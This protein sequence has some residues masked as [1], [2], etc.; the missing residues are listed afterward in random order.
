MKVRSILV[1]LSLLAILSTSVGGYLYHASLQESSLKE[2]E[3]QAVTRALGLR[4]HLSSYLLQ[5]LKSVR[6]MAGLEVFRRAL[7]YPERLE[8]V[9]EANR[10]L[11]H[12]QWALRA[13]V[14][15]L[16]DRRGTTIYSSNRDEPLS[17]VDKNYGFRPYFT[18]A[19]Q[20][21][22]AVYM[23][24]GVTSGKRGVYYSHPVYGSGPFSGPIGVGVIK[25]TIEP[26]ETEFSQVEGGIVVLADPDGVI[27]A[28]SRKD[29]LLH[30]LWDL[31]DK[32]RKRITASRQFGEGSLTWVGLKEREGRRA[33]DREGNR[34]M[35]HRIEVP[36]H[37]GWQILYLNSVD[38]FIERLSHP[39]IR[40]SGIVIL[41]LCLI[42][43]G[44][45]FVLYR[46]ASWEI[47]Q[48]KKAEGALRESEETARALLNAPTDSALLLDAEGRVLAAN[49]SAVRAFRT[50]VE[51]FVGSCIFAWFRPETA[52]SERRRLKT[53]LHSGKPIR[54][55]DRRGERFFD[56]HLYP[57]FGMKGRV[58]RVAI[59]SLDITEIKKTEE[60]LRRTQEELSRYSRNLERQ[61]RQRTREITSI[62]ENTP[63]VVTIKDREYRYTMVG[64]RFEELFGIT[65][66]D[67]KDKTDYEIFPKAVADQFR[68]ND[69]KVALEQKPIQVEE[70][71]P[72]EDGVHTYLSV[73]FPLND[74]TGSMLAMCGIST[75]ITE[76]KKAQD[77]LRRL[78]GRIMDSQEQERALI[79]RELHDELGQLL[80]AL[81]MDAVW[82]RNHLGRTNGGAESRASAMC[83]LIDRTID[84]V[85]GI[86]IRLRPGVLDD[87]GLIEALEWYTEEFDRRSEIVC[88]FRHQDIPPIKDWIATAAYRI[89]Q[90]AM[91]NAARH[92]SAAN[93]DVSLRMEDHW[94]VLEVM[95][96][97]RGFDTARLSEI[98]CLGVA[99][100]RERAV[101]V[102]GSLEIRSRP[103]QGTRV[104]FH[105]PL[106][107]SPGGGNP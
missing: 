29:W 9:V 17:F 104:R 98:D 86:A 8:N 84:E 22:T 65:S 93:V 62:L 58:I 16:M 53:I 87:L 97:G 69:E 6:A 52:E 19:I 44:G 10:L 21:E 37:P 56:T 30:L 72:Q 24:L 28:S 60:E 76:L 2:V 66:R 102:G 107:G 4:N 25:A 26:V 40:I 1:V 23:A 105:V 91:T 43:G 34:Y 64:P 20:G 35:I 32:D 73:K 5:N 27:F 46:K 49:E 33:V 12:F 18:R 82:L 71:V 3:R 41:C 14:C 77:Q 7:E 54:Y 68:T 42:V 89:A 38:L 83:G 96:D 57:V 78:S 39:L 50:D 75:D 94:M 13:D 92:A 106:G 99:G 74:E 90:E 51:K 15:Y 81:R 100:M 31:P 63:A 11:D 95:D 36:E 67:V 55:E 103:G 59:F 70:R 80:T 47:T 48:R 88:M 61:V 101:L 85:R 79:A 45:V